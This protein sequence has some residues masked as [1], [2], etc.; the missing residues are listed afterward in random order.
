MD[1]KD[2]TTVTTV[3]FETVTTGVTGV[4]ETVT[5]V[6]TARDHGV[7]RTRDLRSD[8]EAPTPAA[9]RANNACEFTARG[10]EVFPSSWLRC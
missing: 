1:V 3:T 2:V 10:T 4:Y 9:S 8:T 7:A 6:V 5:L